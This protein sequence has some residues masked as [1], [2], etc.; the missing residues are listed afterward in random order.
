MLLIHSVY[1]INVAL[2]TLAEMLADA[3]NI[4]CPVRCLSN[5]RNDT[6]FPPC[7]CPVID[8]VL[9]D[10]ALEVEAFR[11]SCARLGASP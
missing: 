11:L 5:D 7:L 10:P 1:C 8:C 4:P 9:M 2:H 6:H 3:R